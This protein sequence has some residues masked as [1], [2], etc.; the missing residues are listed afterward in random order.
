VLDDLS[1]LEGAGQLILLS[2]RRI[3]DDLGLTDQQRQ[4]VEAIAQ[5]FSQRRLDS[6]EHFARLTLVQRRERFLELARTNEVSMRA[7]LT[8][9]QLKRLEQVTL[10]LQGPGVF[11][12]SEVIASLHLSDAQRQA[13]RQ[14]EAEGLAPLWEHHRGG[15]PAAPGVRE[16]ML[17]ATM[18]KALALLSPEQLAQWN[19]MIGTPLKDVWDIPHHGPGMPL[20]GGHEGF[21]GPPPMNGEPPPKPE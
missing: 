15:R 20:W 13:I 3:Q 21:R 11:G 8:P 17:R 4:Q 1:L 7:V 12:Q 18:E 10:Q 14:I 6:L 9:S 2:D 5:K 19:E 16:A